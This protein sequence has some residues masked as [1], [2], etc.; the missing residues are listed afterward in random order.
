[1][2]P[3]DG[4]EMVPVSDEGVSVVD[5]SVALWPNAYASSQTRYQPVKSF[6]R[7]VTPDLFRGGIHV[8]E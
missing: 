6:R 4:R 2:S 5:D 8:S 7:T 1:M 3:P